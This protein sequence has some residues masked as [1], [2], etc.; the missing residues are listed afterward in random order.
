VLSDPAASQG[1]PTQP[2]P[3]DEHVASAH[4][5]GLRYVSDALPGIRRKRVG[6]GFR[7]LGPDGQV[8][9]DPEILARIRAL[10][11]PPAWK[12]V[13]ICPAPNGHIQATARDAK[14][15]KQ[16]RYHPKYREVRDE[17]KFGRMLEF[18][19][20]LPQIRGRVEQDLA[21]PGLPRP[22]VLA[23]VVWLL[24]KTLIR[25]GNTE[26][27]KENRSYGLT[28]LKRRHVAVSGSNLRFSFRGKSRVSHSVAITD[29]RIARIV[30]HCQTLPGEELFQYLDDEGRR[31]TVDSGDINDYLEEIS[32]R[33]DVTAKDFRTWVGTMLAA[34]ALRD[35]GAAGTEKEAKRN[36]VRVIDRVAQRLG[37]TRAVCRKYYIHPAIQEAY[38]RGTVPPEP[39]PPNT[40]KREHPAAALRREEYTLLAF[41]QS[42]MRESG[43]STNSASSPGASGSPK[44]KS[45]GPA[46]GDRAA[47]PL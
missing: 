28:T 21:R 3:P 31:Q 43:S 29:R 6:G 10:V 33:Q 46:A 36:L 26:Y 15:R 20:M 11:I 2:T 5:A 14:G 27:A 8:I 4:A 38:L 32:G 47:D 44:P 35:L 34:G 41:L 18:S 13:W 40:S 22:K 9:Q 25:V 42:L 16:Y 19:E 23:T 45:A 39:P 30:Q 1:G 17:T 12:D 37:N 7:F 24:E